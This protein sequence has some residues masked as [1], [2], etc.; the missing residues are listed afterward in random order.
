[1]Q[2][3]CIW[4]Q[5][6]RLPFCVLFYIYRATTIDV[7]RSGGGG[8]CMR[9]EVGVYSRVEGAEHPQGASLG[10]ESPLGTAPD[11]AQT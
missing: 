5:Y 8:A 11:T 3:V 2:A 1:M 9:V 4:P 10:A 7:L 6:P